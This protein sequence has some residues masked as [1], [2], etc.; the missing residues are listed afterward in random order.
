MIEW[1]LLARPGLHLLLHVMVPGIFARLCWPERWKMAWLVMMAGM[2]IDLDHLLADTLYDPLRC[3]LTAHPLHGPIPALVYLLLLW[4]RK[5]RVLACGLLI[6]LAL[7]GSD[8]LMMLA[9]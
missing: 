6:H 3:S 1:L 8:C 7:D 2:L 4:P 5:T 9:A